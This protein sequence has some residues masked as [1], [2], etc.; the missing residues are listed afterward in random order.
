MLG[1]LSFEQIL[2]YEGYLKKN[3]WIANRET[4][5]RAV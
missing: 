1:E 3:V 2:P 4:I 5:A